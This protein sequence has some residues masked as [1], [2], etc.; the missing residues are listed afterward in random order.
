MKINYFYNNLEMIC[1]IRLHNTIYK[2]D[3][4]SA[5][6][7]LHINVPAYFHSTF[8]RPNSYMSS[9]NFFLS[10][11]VLAVCGWIWLLNY[12]VYPQYQGVWD[13][14]YQAII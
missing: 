4:C 14:R 13:D 11:V 8:C 3:S 2:C 12:P 10:S 6:G 5:A 1:R 9:T 7:M